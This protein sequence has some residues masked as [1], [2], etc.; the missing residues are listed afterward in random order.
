MDSFCWWPQPTPLSCAM[1]IKAAVL[2]MDKE[3]LFF[4]I[5]DIDVNTLSN[6]QKGA[7]TYFRQTIPNLGNSKLVKYYQDD[8]YFKYQYMGQTSPITMT[9]VSADRVSSDP[10]KFKL[11]ETIQSFSGPLQNGRMTSSVKTYGIESFSDAKS[12]LDWD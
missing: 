12:N 10:L 5:S 3:V 6:D 2:I 8:N 1:K 11:L 7:D 4:L 9:Q